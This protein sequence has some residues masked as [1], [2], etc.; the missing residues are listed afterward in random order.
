MALL[1]TDPVTHRITAQG[2]VD[3]AAMSTTSP[4]TG[5]LDAIV[6]GARTR[7]LLAV[8]E[9]FLNLD[10]GV[11]WYEDPGV[12]PERV[13]LGSRYDEPRVR[14]EILTAL[15]STPGI[16]EITALLIEFDTATRGVTITWESKTVFGD[17]DPD[18]LQ[19]G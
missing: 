1:I 8:G 14:A 3:V 18:T 16:L 15:L 10:A 6:I 2:L 17:T 5:G 11:P 13:I 4:F 7:L 9:W 12:D 19:V